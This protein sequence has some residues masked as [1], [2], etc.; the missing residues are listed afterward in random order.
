LNTVASVGRILLKQQKYAEAEPLL[1]EAL[2]GLEK[3]SPDAW[4]R[5]NTQSMLGGALM[6][7]HNYGEAEPLLVSGYNGLLERESRIPFSLR[8]ALE[9]AGERVVQLYR[10]WGM[11][12]KAAA[13][14]EKIQ[15]TA[16]DLRKL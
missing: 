13:W 11:P 5:F 9:Q 1:R 8:Q 7:Q 10:D 4:G 12:E 3:R 2:A 16:A 6:G 14:R 15:A